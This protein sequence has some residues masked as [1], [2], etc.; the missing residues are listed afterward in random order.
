VRREPPF[1]AVQIRL[2]HG[3]R[4]MATVKSRYQEMSIKVTAGWKRVLE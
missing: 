3:S 4:G 1:S 2:E